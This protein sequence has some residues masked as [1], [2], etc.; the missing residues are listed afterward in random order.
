VGINKTFLSEINLSRKTKETR[1]TNLITLFNEVDINGL[2]YFSTE[3]IK[4]E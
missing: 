2:F 4:K 3:V 1:K